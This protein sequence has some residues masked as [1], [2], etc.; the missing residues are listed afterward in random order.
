M[1]TSEDLRKVKQSLV[2]I[3]EVVSSDRVELA[4]ELTTRQQEMQRT[5]LNAAIWLTDGGRGVGWCIIW[6]SKILALIIAVF[7]VLELWKK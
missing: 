4:A 6:A 3:E 5:I 1:A 2:S 7:A